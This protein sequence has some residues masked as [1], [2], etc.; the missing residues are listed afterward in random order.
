MS[1][2]GNGI[3]FGI[4]DRLLKNE[5]ITEKQ[6]DLAIKRADRLNIPLHRAIVDLNYASEV[7]TYRALAELNGLD[8]IDCTTLD[9]TPE[10]LKVVPIK[11]IFHYRF[12]PIHDEGGQIT[13]AF[14]E[15]P[16]PGEQGNLR[17]LLGKRL[18]IVITTPSCIH[19]ILKTHF[20]LGAETIQKL[21]QDSSLDDF[22]QQI[23]FDVDTA[24]M[25]GNV[26]V[27][28]ANFVDQILIE[29]LRLDATDIHI[30]PYHETIHLRYR[31]DGVLQP[32]PVPDG[33]RRLYSSI[34]SR[35]K[36]MAGLD[37]SEKRVPHDGRIAM[38]TDRESYD[39][40]VST[41]PTTHGE[42][43]CLRIL[44]RE[45]LF[46]DLGNLGLDPEQER[47]LAEMTQLPG[48]LILLTGPTGSGKTTT[49][50]AALAHANSEGRKIITIEDPVEYQLE[51]AMQI[52]TRDEVGLTFSTGLRS[53]LRHDPDVILIGEI[54][55]R[56]TA[57]IAIRSA[58]TGHLVFSTLHTNDSVSAVVRLVE[59]GIDPFLVASSLVGSIAQR[60][61]QR[62]CRSCRTDAAPVPEPFAKEM[63]DALSD[64]T[65]TLVHHTGTGCVECNQHGY[66]GRVGLY[67][68]FILNDDIADLVSDRVKPGQLRNVART[69]GWRSLRESGWKKVQAG[70]ISIEELQRI[71][72]R[73]QL[74]QV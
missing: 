61:A 46:R 50:Y 72:R 52:Q 47:T 37:I 24:Q 2:N 16:P 29:A 68:F 43:V 17:L 65:S 14:A 36:I 15:P 39:L 19:A 5:L 62:I 71:T 26:D 44:G 59:M 22:E 60:L 45:N 69:F 40:R 70:Q 48:G 23:V 34:V 1:T 7:A 49:L 25:S 28:I 38:K 64:H 20:G 18:K 3:S 30:E 51:G 74:M 67:E 27:S 12:I 57:E 6:L 31:I 54:R 58:Q 32:I 8:F 41:L 55:D 56:E 73:V 35:L 53:V 11:L 66:R 9:I 10:S 4:G 33:L 42:G 13:V 21:R 63:A